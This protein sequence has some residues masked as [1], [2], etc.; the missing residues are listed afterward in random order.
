MIKDPH[1]FILRLHLFEWL[2]CSFMFVNKRTILNENCVHRS[3]DQ[4]EREQSLI[5]LANSIGRARVVRFECRKNDDS[6]TLLHHWKFS[7]RD[8]ELNDS[9]EDANLFIFEEDNKT[10]KDAAPISNSSRFTTVSCQGIQ[11]IITNSKAK[12]TRKNTNWAMNTFR[13]R[14][15][16]STTFGNSC[17]TTAI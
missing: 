10:L 13:G 3:M 2:G 5:R 9:F 1:Q 4:K 7:E 12:S 8:L 6:R 16:S 15:M 17:L 14:P 11:D